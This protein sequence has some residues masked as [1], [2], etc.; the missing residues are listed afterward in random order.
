MN[1]GQKVN[2]SVLNEDLTSIQHENIL[3]FVLFL[4]QK[5]HFIC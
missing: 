1:S 2:M 4:S 5:N 3:F